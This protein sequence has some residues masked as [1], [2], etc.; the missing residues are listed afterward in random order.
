LNPSLDDKTKLKSDSGVSIG[1]RSW[2]PECIVGVALILYLSL[3]CWHIRYPGI[4]YDEAFFVNAALGAKYNDSFIAYRILGI[5]VMLMSYI[6]ALKSFVYAPIFAVC[7][8]SPLTIRLPAIIISTYSLLITYALLIQ[9][10]PRIVSA[11]GLLLIAVDA[12]FVFQTRTDFGPIAIMIALKMT[13]I[14]VFMLWLKTGNWRYFAFGLCCLALGVYDKLNFLWVVFALCPA[15]LIYAKRIVYLLKLDYAP[16]VSS[17]VIYLGALAMFGFEIA[18][19]L[20]RRMPPVK[21]EWT[22]ERFQLMLSTFDRTLTGQLFSHLVFARE[23]LVGSFC[24]MWL[25]PVAFSGALI[26]FLLLRRAKRVEE[27]AIRIFS[28]VA[29]FTVII[30]VL[31]IE[32]LATPEAQ[33][34]HHVLIV[35]PF[36]YLIVILAISLMGITCT[37]KVRRAAGALLAC[38]MTV[39][40]GNNL[41]STAKVITAFSTVPLRGQWS[42]HVY[43]LNNLI[44]DICP[45]VNLVIFADWGLCNQLQALCPCIRTKCFDAWVLLTDADESKNARLSVAKV[46]SVD[47]SAVV[48][49]AQGRCILP[50]ARRNVFKIAREN[51]ISLN[52]LAVISDQ[53]GPLYEVYLNA[54]RSSD[55]PADR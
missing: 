28:G 22:E 4:Y 7:G 16:L 3:A 45:K 52:R 37:G 14:Y 36:H 34:P 35:W 43:D 50:S 49:F 10:V 2:L 20:L 17:V 44:R 15:A 55:Q 11:L 33:G 1:R 5:P 24:P 27:V 31:F 9:F 29:F 30:A 40:I 21:P 13:A 51:G 42:Y 53:S 32:V 41:A 46:L 48:V 38:V 23:V 18:L 19:P 39:W 12:P 47:Q 25:V 8:V 26:A 6:G 54:R